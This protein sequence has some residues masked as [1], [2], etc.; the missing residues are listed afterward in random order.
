LAVAVSEICMTNQIGCKVSLD[1]VPGEKLDVDRIL[2]SESHS[3]YLLSFDEKN[4]S[5]IESLL[6]TNKVSFKQI[7]QFGG[8]QIQFTNASKLI[9]D[10]DLKKAHDIW[11]HAL[12]NLVLH[13]KNT[14]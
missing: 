6:K 11:L 7:G 13:G 10:I 3:R 5:E 14:V 1:K 9:I 4:L 12:P 2:F 8:E